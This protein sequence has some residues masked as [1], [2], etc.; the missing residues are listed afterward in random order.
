MKYAALISIGLLL[1]TFASA[2]EPINTQN[3][4]TVQQRHKQVVPYD[5]D[6]VMETFSKT[7]HG[8]VMHVVSKSADNAEQIKLIQ[9]YLS[10]LASAFRKGDFSGTEKMHG[11]D[12]PGLKQLKAAKQDDIRYTYKA[13]PDGGQIHFTTEYPLLV[14]ALH[15]WFDAQTQDHGNA[16]VPGHVKHHGM[17]SE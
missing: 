11:A 1:S 6:K 17:I 5:P 10:D 16:A 2:E 8:G 3:Q 4:T 13:L 9:A 14:Q 7:V 15:E 12:M